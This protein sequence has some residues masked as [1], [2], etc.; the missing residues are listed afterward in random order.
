MA[1]GLKVTLSKTMLVFLQANVDSFTT[2][3]RLCTAW[4][5]WSFVVVV[6]SVRYLRVVLGPQVTLFEPRAAS[7][8]MVE[9]RARV[10]ADLVSVGFALPFV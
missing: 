9:A 1:S 4:L 10:R 2:R 5:A 8:Q 6:S 7:L 3:R